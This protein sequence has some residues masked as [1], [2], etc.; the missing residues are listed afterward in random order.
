MRGP[1]GGNM[2]GRMACG[3][4]YVSGLLK[5]DL[6]ARAYIRPIAKYTAYS[7]DCMQDKLL[8]GSANPA[9]AFRTPSRAKR[10]NSDSLGNHLLSTKTIFR[11]F[12]VGFA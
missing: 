5:F 11:T 7:P 2:A 4:R 1:L 12:P 10:E 6:A 9:S 8:L 3:R